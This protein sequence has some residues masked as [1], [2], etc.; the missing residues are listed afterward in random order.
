MET[1]FTTVGA[2]VPYRI[3]PEIQ[4]NPDSHSVLSYVYNIY[5]G[6]GDGTEYDD[7]GQDRNYRNAVND[8]NY[9]GYVT[10][11]E[12]GNIFVYTTNGRAEVPATQI[13]ELIEVICHYRQT[14]YLE[15]F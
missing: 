13:D 3:I 6:A 14:H 10:I 12:P 11:E 15:S 1:I 8:R 7:R 2:G 5:S 9:M 4:V